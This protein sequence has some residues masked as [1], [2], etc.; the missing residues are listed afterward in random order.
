MKKLVDYYLNKQTLEKFLTK[1]S[2]FWLKL[3]E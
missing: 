2:I 3:L 1:L